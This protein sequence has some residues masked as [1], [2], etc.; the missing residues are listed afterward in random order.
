[1][2]YQKYLRAVLP[3]LIM[4]V[5]TL[6]MAMGASASN[7]QERKG[8][9]KPLPQQTP[10]KPQPIPEQRRQEARKT[11][12]P[13]R[14][15]LPQQRNQEVRNLPGT[16]PPAAPAESETRRGLRITRTQQ[17]QIQ[18]ERYNTYNVRWQDRQTLQTN[19]EDQL[20]RNNRGEYLRYQNR[21]WERLY[22]DE[23]RL[24]QPR[25]NN[26]LYFNYGYWRSGTYF[27]TSLYGTQ[28]IEQ[29]I[30]FGYEEGYRAGRA[31]RLDGWGYD[32][33]QSYGYIDAIYGYDRNYI[34]M[35]EYSYYFREGFIRGYEDGYFG[36][37]RYG[38][39]LNGTFMIS[40][41]VL[42]AIFTFTKY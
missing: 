37:Y 5:L 31:D 12:L 23:L 1:M 2:K 6:T 29:A 39:Y 20:R 7:Y 30:R 36:V 14:I 9:Q 16:I 40:N 25:Y 32:P 38:S 33:Y 42:R 4:A 11:P 17:E 27:Y 26:N 35:A 28:M 41:S 22:R 24:R 18:R 8:K 3:L 34:S 13:Q 21:Y 15:P 19:R 10:P